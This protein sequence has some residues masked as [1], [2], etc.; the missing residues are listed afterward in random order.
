M[1][2]Y[3]SILDWRHKNVI[4]ILST[5]LNI[6]EDKKYTNWLVQIVFELKRILPDYI[7]MYKTV[8]IVW[9]NSRTVIIHENIYEIYDI[10]FRYMCSYR[11]LKLWIKNDMQSDI[12]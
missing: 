4:I 12:K 1:S 3:V 8:E 5:N 2:W 7:A 9:A 11:I 6:N 10:S